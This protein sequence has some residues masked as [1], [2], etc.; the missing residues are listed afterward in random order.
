MRLAVSNIAW[1]VA[2]EDEA[3][4][5]VKDAC[6]RGIEVAPT[7][8]WPHWEVDSEEGLQAS[9][10]LAGLG[11]FVPAL[12]AILFGKPE[13]ELFGTD[14]QRQGLR[15]HLR[16]CAD[17]ARVLGARSLV[18]GAPKNRALKGIAPERAFDIAREF[19]SSVGPDYESRGVCL[20]LEA[21]PDQY[22]CQF[23]TNSAEA[24]R[25]VRVV[26]S[27]GFRLHLDTACM[28]LAG[29][30]ILTA[31]RANF[32]LVHHFHVS[33]PFLGPFEVPAIDHTELAAALRSLRYQGCVSLEMR[34]AE[35]C[36]DNLRR[37]V[38]FLTQT[39]SEGVE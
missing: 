2:L 19:F 20:C 15:D 5:I 33:Q 7:R 11:F 4:G 18:F 16:I 23:V 24:A 13:C 14:E 22:G 39:Y 12:Q 6:I 9:R 21:N 37:A 31:L 29:E 27:P 36:L 8:W 10:R 32:D 17:L 26:D 1:P 35:P 25:L 38:N 30:E 3:L 28:H 34:E